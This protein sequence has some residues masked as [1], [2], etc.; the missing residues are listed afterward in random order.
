MYSGCGTALA[1]GPFVSTSHLCAAIPAYC[2]VK[3]ATGIASD[4][5]GVN[6]GNHIDC[7]IGYTEKA[8]INTINGGSPL[9][10]I[11]GTG[12]ECVK[13]YIDKICDGVLGNA[14]CDPN[15][16]IGPIGVD[17]VHWVSHK[18][19]LAYR[20]N[21]ENDSLQANT[22]A[23]RI[24]IRQKLDT[25]VN[26]LSVRLGEFGFA[27]Q[28]FQIP[29][30]TSSYTTR[31]NLGSTNIG[32]DV[33]VTAGLDIVNRE[34]FWILQSLQA[35]KNIPPY[36]PKQGLL[37]V[38]DTLGNGQGYVTYTVAPRAESRT[39]DSVK[40]QAAIY[41]DVN[42]P[43]IT[44]TWVNWIDAG[45]PT[46]KVNALPTPIDS[47][48]I[49]LSWTGKD[50]TLGS[51]LSYYNLYVSDNNAPYTLVNSLTDSST[52]YTG[53]PGHTYSFY[54]LA[55]DRVKNTEGVKTVADAT[56]RI[57]AQLYYT[58]PP[59]WKQYYSG[60]TVE[61]SWFAYDIKN[62]SNT[63]TSLT[64]NLVNENWGLNASPNK[65]IWTVPAGLTRPDT[66]VMTIK[67]QNFI[68]QEAYDTIIINPKGVFISPKV[69]LQGAYN[70]STGWMG[71]N[72][73]SQ[74][75]IPLTEP[76][77][78]MTGF[79]HV[80]GG[81]ET[82]TNTV[83]SVTG[84][85]AIVDWVFVEL[86][87]ASDPLV[88]VATRAALIQRDGDIVDT[89][90]VSPVK[91]SGYAYDDYYVAIKH[92]NH[93]GLRSAGVLKLTA[94]TT[95]VDFTSNL[96]AVLAPPSGATYDA[97]ATVTAGVYGLWGGNTNGD[98]SVKMT[99]FSPANND[100]LKLLNTL[101]S[102]TAIQSAVY[103]NQDLNMDGTVKMTGFSP[104][105]NDYLKL[106]NIL[107][108]ATNSIL[109]PY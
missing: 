109:Q 33:E 11:L 59:R 68:S 84:N 26:P 41:F 50:D 98:K 71:D 108:A 105:N 23:Q 30:K 15:E 9:S 62:I 12:W 82:T 56:V 57:K 43:V 91:F 90:G 54:T 95:V 89:D 64:S 69:Y 39:R 29:T 45:T 63:Y 28:R 17:T 5:F 4:C 18:D 86:R 36:D 48:T 96:S 35:G 70:A 40:A 55:T 73:R 47:T 61:V 101:G 49:H 107:G 44:N 85:D 65:Q 52:T 14:P 7:A 51:G 72:L 102:S 38:N 10:S 79:T 3:T 67:D 74:G 77:T 100:Y 20:V 1:G 53:V 32:V 31:L 99:G 8:V 97:L 46:S 66:I 34:V 75:L 37:P 104:A 2:I 87:S 25:T 60:D 92:R 78:G 21:F 80:G 81:G 106:L 76:Y 58:Y 6:N 24:V 103:S 27:N 13:A 22:A 83:L 94:T 93:L 19:T 42:A 88:V 16:I